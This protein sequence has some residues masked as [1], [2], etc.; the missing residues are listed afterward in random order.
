MYHT[1][2][3]KF[4]KV[5][6]VAEVDQFGY[7]DLVDVFTHGAIPSNLSMKDAE[8]NEIGDPS[9]ILGTPKDVFHAH[10]L[11]AEVDSRA[12]SVKASKEAAQPS[13]AAPSVSDEAK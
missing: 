9:S 6:D 7:I 10:R 13:L 5:K 12:R 4:D 1:E 2:D 3:L 8:F 11:A